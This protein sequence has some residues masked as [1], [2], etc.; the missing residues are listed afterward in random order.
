MRHMGGSL[1]ATT[2]TIFPHDDRLRDTLRIGLEE[3][4]LNGGPLRRGGVG[5]TWA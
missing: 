1:F 2:N 5:G 4:L 3:T